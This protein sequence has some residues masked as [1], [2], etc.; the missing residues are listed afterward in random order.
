ML[1]T[2]LAPALL[3]CF[4]CSETS[5]GRHGGKPD[6]TAGGAADAA[7]AYGGGGEDA[8]PS[9]QTDPSR[10]NDGDGWSVTQGDCNDC[11]RAFNPGAVELPGNSV[12]DD[13]NNQV[14]EINSAC[15]GS[16]S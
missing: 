14:D 2:L 8:A 16:N 11:N 10:D 7:V 12:D 9:C 15:D 1:K 6:G 5:A 4:G 3:A 13:C